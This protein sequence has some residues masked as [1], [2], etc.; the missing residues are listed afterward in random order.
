MSYKAEVIA[1]GSGK[2]V[3]NMLR[4]ATAD[5]AEAYAKDLAWRWTAVR[6]TRVVECDDPPTDLFINGGLKPYSKLAQSMMLDR[7][8]GGR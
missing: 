8:G 2:W 7:Q 1:D 6:D 5:E 4:F 3:G